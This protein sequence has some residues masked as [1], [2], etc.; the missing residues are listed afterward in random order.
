M[1]RVFRLDGLNLLMLHAIFQSHNHYLR[2]S[3]LSERLGKSPQLISKKA[4]LLER[5]GYL[6]R[7]RKGMILEL[8]L[9][10]LGLEASSRLPTDKVD[11]LK[12]KVET[13]PTIRPHA[14]EAKFRLR[15]PLARGT[16]SRILQAQGI[17]Q[18][19]LKLRNQDGAYYA[20][21]YNGLLTSTNLIIYAQMVEMPQDADIGLMVI[22]RVKGLF[23]MAYELEARL[24]LQLARDAKGLL[25]AI[26]IKHEIAFKNHQI[27]KDAKANDD[28]IYAY[29]PSTK[30]LIVV[31]DFSHGF[32]E[33]EAVNRKSAPYNAEEI[34]K[35]SSW[36]ATGSMRE[37]VDDT[38]RKF[39]DIAGIL[40]KQNQ[41]FIRHNDLIA[42]VSKLI[43]ELR[44][45]RAQRRLP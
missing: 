6:K 38:D 41:F 12:H 17:Y 8:W 45:E 11:N 31:S 19:D 15:N 9:T 29:D 42:Q 21:E 44:K 28:K 33:F 34:Q 2:V 5:K 23:Q 10:E 13:E 32:P 1:V 14:F 3:E 35:A 36:M 4:V 18:K 37:W 43:R 24:G 39:S 26:V 22:D 7:I 16:P 25:T 27:A 40:D 20:G 30:E